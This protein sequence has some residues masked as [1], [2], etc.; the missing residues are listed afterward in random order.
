M[1]KTLLLLLTLLLCLGALTAC[2]GRDDYVPN[3]FKRIS[4]DNAEYYLYVP[5]SWVSDLSTGVTAAY[6]SEKDRSSI[7]FMAFEVND[8]ILQVT[9]AETEAATDAAPADETAETAETG[10]VEGGLPEIKTVE[11][12]WA[13]Y[14]TQFASTFSDMTYS[15]KGEDRMLAGMKAK[16]YVYT[17]SVTGTV[18]QFMQVAALKEGTVY[19]FTYTSTEEVFD[20]HLEEV[21]KI[22]EYISLK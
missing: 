19:I 3:G 7:S 22:L 6:V 11:E 8:A 21:G 4:H 18:Y 2:G 1:K 15:K 10:E 20:S 5:T 17:A 9:P 12:Y 13:Y 14:E 16:T